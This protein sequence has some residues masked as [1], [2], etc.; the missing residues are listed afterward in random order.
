MLDAEDANNSMRQD[1][2]VA[3]LPNEIKGIADLTQ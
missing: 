2:E 1:D 3:A